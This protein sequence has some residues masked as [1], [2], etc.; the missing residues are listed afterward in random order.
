MILQTH[1]LYSIVNAFLLYIC[2]VTALVEHADVTVFSWH[3][4]VHLLGLQLCDRQTDGRADRRQ[5]RIKL[6]ANKTSSDDRGRRTMI[7][8]YGST[9]SWDAGRVPTYWRLRRHL[10]R[11]A[12]RRWRWLG[13]TVWRVQAC[14]AESVSPLC[15]TPGQAARYSDLQTD[16]RHQPLL[17]QKTASDRTSLNVNAMEWK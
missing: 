17:G 12:D 7:R 10:D 8:C 2:T 13:R 14:A 9:V 3:I 15:P 4:T 11:S 5:D 16:R 1:C 6:T